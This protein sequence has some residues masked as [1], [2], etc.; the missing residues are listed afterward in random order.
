MK[1]T[2][3]LR[4]TLAL[5]ALAVLSA[6]GSGRDLTITKIKPPTK[7]AAGTGLTANASRLYSSKS[8]VGALAL[9]ATAVRTAFFAGSGP[10]DVMTILGALD[11]RLTEIE[12]SARC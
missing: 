2:H 6:C 1:L 12:E 9:D 10:T 4:S 11:R 7:E 5:S 8:D 3:I